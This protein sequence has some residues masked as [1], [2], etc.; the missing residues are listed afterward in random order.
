MTPTTECVDVII[1]VHNQLDYVQRLLASLFLGEEPSAFE[2]VVIDDCSTD[3]R[4][5]DLLRA[6]ADRGQIRLIVNERN[7][8]FTGSARIGMIQRAGRDIV[9]LNSDTEVYSDWLTRLKKA[10]A[11]NYNVC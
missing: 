7:L 10:C 8:G 1:P 5:C 6:Y 2:V 3:Q 11:T 4:V 9:L